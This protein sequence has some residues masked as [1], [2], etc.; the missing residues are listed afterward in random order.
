[1][2]LLSTIMAEAAITPHGPD[3]LG[4]ITGTVTDKADGKTISEVV[5]QLL[6]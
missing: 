1:M 2:L 6:G 3:E 5:R 4:T